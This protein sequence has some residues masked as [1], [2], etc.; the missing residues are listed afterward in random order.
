MLRHQANKKNPKPGNFTCF[1]IFFYK[2][3]FEIPMEKLF[4]QL[5]PLKL[6]CNMKISPTLPVFHQVALN[7]NVVS[8]SLSVDILLCPFSVPCVHLTWLYVFAG[9]SIPNKHL[10]SLLF[11][12]I[13]ETQLRAASMYYVQ[14]NGETYFVSQRLCGL[15][16]TG[17]GKGGI[18]ATS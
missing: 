14:C 5:F 18:I 12:I 7:Q 3:L 8:F 13:T 15:N 11:V 17:R 1:G 6:S 9:F 4:H 2:P 10:H 16:R